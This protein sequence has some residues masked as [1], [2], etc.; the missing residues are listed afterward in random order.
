MAIWGLNQSQ[1]FNNTGSAQAFTVPF[2]GLYKLECNGANTSATGAYAVRHIP[3]TRGDVLY[4]ACGKGSSGVYVGT[5]YS[6]GLTATAAWNG[7]G[8]G[9]ANVCS[10]ATYAQSGAG[11]THIAIGTNRGE[12]KNYSSYRDEILIVAGGAGGACTRGGK[13]ATAGG[14]RGYSTTGNKFGQGAAGGSGDDASSG[15]GGGWMG[16]TAGVSGGG[17][18]MV[19]STGGSSYIGVEAN[20]SITTYSGVDYDNYITPSGS[21][22]S[23]LATITLVGHSFEYTITYEN[24]ADLDS[25]VSLGASAPIGYNSADGATISEPSTNLYDFEGW[26]TTADFSGSAITSIPA[27]TTGDITLYAKWAQKS[28]EYSLTKAVETFTAPIDGLYQLEV[29]GG[30][31]GWNGGKGGYSKGYI[32]LK[33]GTPLYV[34]VGGVGASNGTSTKKNVAGGYNGGGSLSSAY[35]CGAGGGAT[36]IAKD[37]NR[38]VLSK[39]VDNKDEV[40]IVAGGGGGY[41]SGATGGGLTGGGG[42]AGGTQDAGG[43]GNWT[44]GTFGKGGDGIKADDNGS[45]AH[46]G[47]GGG[48]WYGGGGYRYAWTGSGG[49]S[50]YIGG[51]PDITHRGLPYTSTTENGIQSGDGK[52]KITFIAKDLLFYFNGQEVTDLIFNGTN[53]TSLT[54]DGTKI[55]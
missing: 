23:G 39:Y 51:V 12:L 49:G 7:G 19:A 34:C 55:F 54:F 22:S 33:Q 35:W 1:N 48:G 21:T 42:A 4:V 10:E 47:A 50:G 40:L 9:Y 29:W 20:T 3:L 45:H 28:W 41:A 24:I 44:T 17:G 27:G 36:H 8:A 46:Y 14:G 2:D 11:A 25:V 6:S 26:Y 30:Q 15:G 32:Q 43:V 52:A 53:I 31:G 18:Y 13:G 37:N 5:T 38:G 16:G